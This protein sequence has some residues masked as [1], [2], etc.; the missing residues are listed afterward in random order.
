LPAS[1]KI[2]ILVAG[3][4]HEKSYRSE[5]RNLAKEAGRRV[6]SHFEWVPEEDLARFMQATDIAAFPFREITN[7]GSVMLAQS[8]G[9]PVVITDLPS[10]RDI[11]DTSAIRCEP[12]VESLITALLAAEAMSEMQ[13]REMGAAGLAWSM[14]ANW[15]D[16]ADAT[17]HAYED[18]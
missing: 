7:S 10:L 18:L 12:T 8:F 15:A 5:L 16:I 4:C 13:Y 3:T 6:V 11:P 1:S 9:L 2:R 14:R 17:V